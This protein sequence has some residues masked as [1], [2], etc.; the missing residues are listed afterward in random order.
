MENDDIVAVVLL[1]DCPGGSA[2]LSEEIFYRILDL[3]DK[4][5]VV[6]TVD[7]LGA[8]GAY[9]IAS[10]SNYIFA[11]P[12]AFIGSIGVISTLPEGTGP[13][14]RTITTGPFKGSGSSQVDW[15]RSMDVIKETFITNVYD[16]RL[17]ALEHMHDQSRVSVLPDKNSIATGQVW[18]APVAYDI[19]L[20][21]AIGSNMEAI[22]KAADLA[23]VINYEI[24]DL[25]RLIIFDD[26]EHSMFTTSFDLELSTL[27]ISSIFPEDLSGG[28]IETGPWQKYYYL[29][30][31]PIE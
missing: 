7:T 29:Y 19:G 12:A 2:S 17:Y 6:A 4:K 23:H 14:E 15:I 24:V 30:V 27:D 20:I 22:Q 3:R 10:A 9:Y 25:T 11:K 16:Q 26:P 18:I 28:Y 13:S 5:P 31:P 8:S 1:I 21:D